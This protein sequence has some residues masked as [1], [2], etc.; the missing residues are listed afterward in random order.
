MMEI[1]PRLL[2][3]AA[4]KWL[5]AAYSQASGPEEMRELFPGA[6]VVEIG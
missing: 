2:G 3:F 1:I 6:E 4:Y 5:S